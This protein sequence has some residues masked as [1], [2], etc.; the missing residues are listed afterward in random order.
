MNSY[1]QQEEA[2]QSFIASN[3]HQQT[4]SINT[5]KKEL[6]SA[7]S[8]LLEIPRI[9]SSSS[10]QINSVFILA[11]DLSDR[12]EEVDTAISRCTQT[13]SYV[14]NLA[15]LTE[16]LGTI[17]NY[18]SKKDIIQC[19]DHIH[20]LLQI[21]HHL[22]SPTDS[23]KIDS[24]RK[25]TLLILNE[26]L[27]ENPT[28][29]FQYYNKCGAQVEGINQLADLQHKQILEE[30]RDIRINLIQSIK[31]TSNNDENRAPHVEVY[32]KFLDCISS[33]ILTSIPILSDPGQFA[34]FIRLL[35][36]RCDD[37]IEEIISNY[38]DY[39][40][41]H[42]LEMKC[43]ES[44]EIKPAIL[45]LVNDEISIFAHQFALFDNFIKTKIKFGIKTDFFK[46]YKFKF[47]TS[48]S[49]TP[50]HTKFT[51][52]IQFLLVQYALFTQYYLR[53][54]TKELLAIIQSMS[55]TE[56]VVNAIDDLFFILHRTL[57]RS[58]ITDSAS[59]TCTIFNVI[60]LA[61]RDQLMPIIK[62]TTSKL[63]GNQSRNCILMNTMDGVKMYISKLSSMI[64]TTV[65]KHFTDDDLAA[66]SSGL[67]D[68]KN[69]GKQ[70]EADLEI[71][72]DALI[73][74]LR[75]QTEK[76]CDVFL[77]A[78]MANDVSVEME[79][80][81]QEDFKAGF[82]KIF[83][84]YKDLLNKSNY[85]LLL[86]SLAPYFTKRLE[87]VIMSKK[88]DANGAVLMRRIVNWL[89][90]FFFCPSAFER[91]IDI[92]KVLTMQSPDELN[93]KNNEK[94]KLSIEQSIIIRITRLR[95]DWQSTD[96]KM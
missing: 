20:R 5:F 53:S 42:D 7:L 76:L 43:S 80:Q 88:F 52:S 73:R 85:E 64:E 63:G 61:I 96:N 58:V 38:S 8:S 68:L 67:N 34:V 36:D 14:K 48:N 62:T 16:C 41:L 33:H 1:K 86:K 35:L 91:V 46:N 78:Q 95:V 10:K 22:L 39:R 84:G 40:N 77:R 17:D 44:K 65:S 23:A 37:K 56:S 74:N 59:T 32:V 9:F 70:L 29:I 72:F 55:N 66:I 25:A 6:N 51:R 82:G 12:I 3:E 93:F 54:V 27:E 89:E 94:N 45:D 21:P 28:E 18:I 26:K 24:A 92:T 50:Q 60:S 19:C 83:N 31:P 90:T 2:L 81:L 4:E 47:S 11:S 30:T 87:T 71:Q 75:P 79:I 13:A 49:G 15:D 69:C 57:N